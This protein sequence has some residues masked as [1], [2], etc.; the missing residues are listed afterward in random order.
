M[1]LT[2]TCA[3]PGVRLFF[4][5]SICVVY[6]LSFLVDVEMAPKRASKNLVAKAE[7]AQAPESEKPS[8]TLSRR[9]IPVGQDRKIHGKAYRLHLETL[10]TLPKSSNA[11][12][13]TQA[14]HAHV[15]SWASWTCRAKRDTTPSKA[16][17]AHV[18]SACEHLWAS[19]VE[20]LAWTCTD[21]RLAEQLET[22][23]RTAISS[24]QLGFEAASLSGGSSKIEWDEFARRPP[25]QS[26]LRRLV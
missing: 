19:V 14:T 13:R 5:Q 1:I 18:K 11:W 21:V 16:C 12:W 3:R 26:W 4:F 24:K 10:C 6:I 22:A 9:C 17:R 8:R 7:A 20:S 15:P 25:W 2:H 23:V